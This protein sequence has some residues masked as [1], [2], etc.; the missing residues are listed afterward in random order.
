MGN[1]M[2]YKVIGSFITFITSSLFLFY[3]LLEFRFD[4]SVIKLILG[5]IVVIAFYLTIFS[6]Y[7]Y[8]TLEE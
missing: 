5:F 6:V 2:K 4:Y 8:F 3:L 1:T 7:N